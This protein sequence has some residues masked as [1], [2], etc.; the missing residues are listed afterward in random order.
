MFEAEYRGRMYCIIY[1]TKDCFQPYFQLLFTFGILCMKQRYKCYE[2]GGSNLNFEVLG[3][4]ANGPGLGVDLKRNVANPGAAA[5]ADGPGLCNG[6]LGKESAAD[7]G[8][9]AA[10]EANAPGLCV[11]AGLAL[12]QNVAEPGAIAAGECLGSF[13]FGGLGRFSSA[14][15]GHLQFCSPPTTEFGRSEPEIPNTW[16]ISNRPKPPEWIPSPHETHFSHRLSFSRKAHIFS[17]S[18]NPTSRTSS[19]SSGLARWASLNKPGASH[20]R[21]L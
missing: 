6:G 11:D 15:R 20:F 10:T 4:V 19:S 8:V 12:K 2:D 14:F 17:E 1:S 21:I 5:E 18:T 3:G 7:P 9:A 13:G 16:P